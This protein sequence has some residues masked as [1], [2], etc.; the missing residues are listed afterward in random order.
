MSSGMEWT[1]DAVTQQIAN[2]GTGLC[3]DPLR[4]PAKFPDAAGKPKLP[5]GVNT[6]DKASEYQKFAFRPI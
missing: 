4:D 1:H 6:C 3:I 5:L 2:P